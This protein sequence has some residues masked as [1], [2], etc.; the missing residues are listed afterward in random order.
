[1]SQANEKAVISIVDTMN[2][3]LKSIDIDFAFD[4]SPQKSLKKIDNND[5]IV[6]I[7]ESKEQVT[8]PLLIKRGLT[9]E[10]RYEQEGITSGNHGK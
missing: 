2:E 1:M 7:E 9:F 10:G 8:K 3:K 6:P 4:F 5:A